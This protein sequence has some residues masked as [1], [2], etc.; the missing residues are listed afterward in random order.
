MGK[1]VKLP[2]CRVIPPEVF[3]LISRRTKNTSYW[4]RYWSAYQSVVDELIGETEPEEVDDDVLYYTKL[5]LMSYLH[6][7][8]RAALKA[9]G[10]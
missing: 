10:F 6:D 1:V 4:V 8:N 3:R 9:R 2:N 5:H 7:R